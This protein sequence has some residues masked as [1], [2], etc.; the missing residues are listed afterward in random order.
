MAIKKPLVNYDGVLKELAATDMLFG[1]G[2]AASFSYV[3]GELIATPTD[4]YSFAVIDGELII[5][6]TGQG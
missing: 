5:T 6:Y 1:V 3:D 4:L 2:S